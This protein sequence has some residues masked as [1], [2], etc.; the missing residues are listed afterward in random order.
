MKRPC[1]IGFETRTMADA[2]DRRI[3]QFVTEDRHH[4]VLIFV[5]QSGGGLVKEHPFRPVEQQSSEGQTLLL[6]KAQ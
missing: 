1:V 2:K 4:G 3:G 6:A 5:V